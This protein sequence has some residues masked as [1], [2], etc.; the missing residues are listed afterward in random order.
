MLADFYRF[1]KLHSWYKHIRLE[2]EDFY[3][4]Q[5]VGQQARN[6]IHPEVEDASGIHWHFTRSPPPKPHYK[7]RFGPFLRGVEDNTS[8]LTRGGHI[9]WMDNKENFNQW[10]ADNH[11][12]LAGHDWERIAGNCTDPIMAEL[13]EREY[14]K[15]WAAV[16]KVIDAVI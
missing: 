7:V 6:G 5:A 3:M 15:A 14:A 16:K 8:K 2:G 11:P 9:I 1:S 10:I 12:D 4:F 13:H